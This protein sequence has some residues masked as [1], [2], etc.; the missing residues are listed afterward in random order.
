MQE[1]RLALHRAS[2][3]LLRA[4][5]VF[6]VQQLLID[7]H[8]L[9]AQTPGLSLADLD[10]EQKLI[11][12]LRKY[13]ARRSAKIIVVFD[14]GSPGGKS[15]ELSGGGVTAVFAGS[16]T[17]ADRVLMERIRELK[18]PGEWI[19][20]SSDREVQV[21]AARRHLIVWSSPDFVKRL[22][23]PPPAK[24]KASAPV[25]AEVSQADVDEWLNIF[26]DVK[27]DETPAPPPRSAPLPLASAP[28]EPRKKS[29]LSDDDL[30]EWLAI[31][32][33]VPQTNL[34]VPPPSASPPATSAP[35]P[36]KKRRT[37]ASADGGLSPEEVDE[38]LK[39]FGKK[40]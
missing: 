19:V 26:G 36:Q 29:S 13:A 40:K 18:K 14:S 1:A 8:N 34:P 11:V 10:D 7:G 39:I 5:K 38:W 16:H 27:Q 25:E 24:G 33:D 31:F 12:L 4:S 23:P 21:A 9:I 2:C 30:N 17:I 28:T 3:I 32:G 35:T 20:V 15:N 22:I 6:I 37:K